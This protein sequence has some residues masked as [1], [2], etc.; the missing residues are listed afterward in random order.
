MATIIYNFTPNQEVWVIDDCGIKNGLVIQ[1]QV[2]ILNTVTTTE[3]DIRLDGD[4]E[5]TSFDE[6][7]VFAILQDAIDQYE[8]S[9]S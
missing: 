7:V 9:L 3:Y 1:I 4:L 5:T 8:I 2:N 6:D